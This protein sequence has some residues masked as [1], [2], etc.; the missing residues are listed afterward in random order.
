MTPASR[1]SIYSKHP[2]LLPKP[3]L[4]NL[5]LIWYDGIGKQD[6]RWVV[7][8]GT[9]PELEKHYLKSVIHI[10]QSIQAADTPDDEIREAVIIW[11]MDGFSMRQVGHPQTLSS[12]VKMGTKFNDVPLEFAGKV[13]LINA[14]YVTKKAVDIA[15]PFMGNVLENVEVL[16]TNRD[17]WLPR[18]LT[19]F[20]L[21]IV[22]EWFG[23]NNNTKPLWVYGHRKY[24][25]VSS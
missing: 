7:E 14:N 17:V 8:N 3:A 2:V 20:P 6:I 5:V 25:N 4:K 9:F 11:D 23:G 13:F 1:T 16:P 24:E 22:P 19:T 18:L 21:D 10:V 15:R 12:L